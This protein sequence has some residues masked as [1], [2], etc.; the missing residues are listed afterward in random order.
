MQTPARLVLA[1]LVCLVFP[2]LL[3][4]C[5]ASEEAPPVEKTETK[6][7]E[8][9]KEASIPVLANANEDT[10]T[11]LVLELLAETDEADPNRDRYLDLMKLT[12]TDLLYE[13]DQV[14][15][16]KRVEG[17]DWPSRAYTMIGI[18]RLNNLQHCYEHVVANDVPGDLIE[19]GAWRG[20]A[21]IFMRAL[22]AAYGDHERT[23]WVADSFEGLPPP[24]AENYPAD[25]GINLHEFDELAV[26][27]EQVQR[28]FRRYG[29]LD[30]QVR[31]LKGWFKDTLPVAP[32]EKL[33]I[34][35]LD[36]DLY[37]STMDALVNLYPKLSSGG[38]LIVDDYSIIPACKQAVHDYRD[39]H[40]ITEE[41]VKIDNIGVYWIKR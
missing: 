40:G 24:D 2:I 29:L 21:T 27:L 36:G 10:T 32:I 13:N 22:L 3:V 20:G 41:I 26:S 39:E 25:E 7:A 35:R 9:E 11:D 19:T 31:F 5:G 8:T 18:R 4:G 1:S 33:S 37:E 23:V 30:D 17:W 16:R 14:G 6:K 15:R 34:L 38:C 12:L 28:N